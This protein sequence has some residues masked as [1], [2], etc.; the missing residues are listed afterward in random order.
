MSAYFT[1]V[2]N[3]MLVLDGPLTLRCSQNIRKSTHRLK[4]PR[5]RRRS[6]TRASV[7]AISEIS[8]D[9]KSAEST[10]YKS[11][12]KSDVIRDMSGRVTY[13]DTGPSRERDDIKA[14]SQHD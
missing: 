1:R 4:L 2:F 9:P 14:N 6:T 8:M 13:R 12:L 5:L 11:N 3:A 10:P 7:R